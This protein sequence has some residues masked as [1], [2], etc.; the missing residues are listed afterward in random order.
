MEREYSICY[1]DYYVC[2]ITEEKNMQSIIRNGLVPSNGDR[3]KSIMDDRRGV[4]CFDEICNM[5]VLIKHLYGQSNL[6]ALKLLR[7]NLKKRKCYIDERCWNSFYLPNKVMPN[8][9]S[10]LEI[11]DKDKKTCPLTC[12]LDLD[13]YE[14]KEEFNDMNVNSYINFDEYFLSWQPLSKIKIL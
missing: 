5:K 7:F 4:F 14:I 12:L 6:E 13:L 1:N 11:L 3:C 2:H 9:L 8:A 10:Y